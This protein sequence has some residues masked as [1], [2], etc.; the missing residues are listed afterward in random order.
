M[1]VALQMFDNN[2][3]PCQLLIAEPRSAQQADGPSAQDGA[4]VFKVPVLADAEALTVLA[5]ASPPP[6]RCDV[7]VQYRP[8]DSPSPIQVTTTEE[9]KRRNTEKN[10]N[11]KR[12]AMRHDG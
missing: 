3:Q 1:S 10:Q 5:V 8:I 7:G 4:L 2:N 12:R 9:E 6:R 11:K